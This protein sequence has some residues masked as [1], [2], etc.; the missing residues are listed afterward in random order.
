MNQELEA[1][2]EAILFSAAEPVT[3]EELEENLACS[4]EEIERGLEGLSRHYQEENH[5]LKIKSFQEGFLL[6]TAP[7]LADS[8]EEVLTASRSVSLSEAALETLAIVAYFQPITRNEIEEIRGVRADATLNTLQKHD[9]IQEE[10]RRDQPGR[11]IEYGTTENFLY[12]FGI[13]DLSQLPARGEVMERLSA[14]GGGSSSSSSDAGS[15]SGC[16]G[17][18]EAGKG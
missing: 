18:A 11:P 9:L 6:C 2:L 16:D 14:R 4:R 1:V 10:G 8:V 13:S 17:E 5:G 3:L 7:R 15:G 12:F